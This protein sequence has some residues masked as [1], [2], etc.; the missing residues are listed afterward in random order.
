MFCSSFVSSLDMCIV[1]ITC[2]L[3]FVVI[4]LW[5][6]YLTRSISLAPRSSSALPTSV[7]FLVFYR[8][9]GKLLALKMCT[10]CWDSL[11]VPPWSLRLPWIFGVQKWPTWTILRVM[12]LFLVLSILFMRTSCA[13]NP[14]ILYL[15]CMVT[16]WS[17][18]LTRDFDYT[19]VKVWHYSLIGWQ[20]RATASQ[21]HLTLMGE[22]VWKQHSRPWLQR[23]LTR[24]SPSGTLGMGVATHV[25]VGAHKT[26]ISCTNI[27]SECMK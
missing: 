3:L 11:S 21:D 18:Y 27:S 1:T 12:Y 14:I 10:K 25:T 6:I 5:V 22:L 23:R 13:R 20:R 4:A 2:S 19:L 17:G 9:M 24:R 26:P 16:R 15:C 7:C 8:L